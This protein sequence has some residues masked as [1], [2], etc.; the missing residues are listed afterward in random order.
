[1]TLAGTVLTEGVHAFE[2]LMYELPGGMSRK[3]VTVEANATNTVLPPGT[4]LG[5]ITGDNWTIHDNAAS[6][7]SQTLAYNA[8]GILLGATGPDGP[9]VTSLTGQSALIVFREAVFN[10]NLLTWAAGMD[11]SEQ[12]TAKATLRNTADI[13]IDCRS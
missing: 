11:G 8:A 2:G 9:N 12:T 1:M 10:A 6:D 5:K 13:S 3:V 4:V 7:G